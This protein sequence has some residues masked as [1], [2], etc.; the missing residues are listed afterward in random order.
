MANHVEVTQEMLVNMVA[1]IAL[2]ARQMN[3][4]APNNERNVERVTR[5]NREFLSKCPTF[6]RGKDRWT[7]FKKVFQELLLEYQVEDM[8]AKRGLYFAIK[9]S[10][11]IIISSMAPSEGRYANMTIAQYMTAVGEKFSPVSESEQMKGEYARRKQGKQEDIQ[12]YLNE[13]HELFRLAY[14][15][16]GDRQEDLA[17]FYDEATKGVANEAVRYALWECRPATIE[18]FINRAITLVSV[19]RKRIANGHGK[20]G[21]NLDG[22]IPISRFSRPTG[23]GEPME[24]DHLRPEDGEGADEECQCMAL[25]EQG[26]QGPCFF[27]QKRGHIVRNCPRKA[28]GLPKIYPAAQ[29]NATRNGQVNQRYGTNPQG[30]RGDNGGQNRYNNRRDGG[31]RKPNFPR[32]INH[33]GPQGDG[34]EEG[35]AEEGEE[36][37]PEGE[38]E[39]VHFLDALFL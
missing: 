31:D 10:A 15:T 27:C 20:S 12:S 17:D 14:P 32:R 4:R 2:A 33:L 39:G 13:K 35:E 30:M 9:G 28:A 7:H 5:N 22:L 3:D 38:D 29:G 26:F 24:I 23:G 37:T 34:G 19:E 1:E 16:I 21:N 6:E 11:S 25:Q 8:V 18:E 36:E